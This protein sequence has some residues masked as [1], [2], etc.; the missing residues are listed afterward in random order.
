MQQFERFPYGINYQI[1]RKLM[2]I[3]LKT[4]PNYGQHVYVQGIFVVSSI[5]MIHIL[6]PDEERSENKN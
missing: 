1:E 5:S 6:V 3:Q 2:L 4:P